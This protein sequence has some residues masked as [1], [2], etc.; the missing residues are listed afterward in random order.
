[1]LGVDQVF[2]RAGAAAAWNT[3]RLIGCWEVLATACAVAAWHV[4]QLIEVV[5]ISKVGGWRPARLR[6]GVW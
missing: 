1:M 4:L 2:A 3:N 6:V 5:C